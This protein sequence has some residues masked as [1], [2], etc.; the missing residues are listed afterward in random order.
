MS[1]WSSHR[2]YLPI[3]GRLLLLVLLGLLFSGSAVAGATPIGDIA[4]DGARVTVNVEFSADVD[5]TVL[6]ELHLRSR[7]GVSIDSATFLPPVGGGAATVN[8]DGDFLDLPRRGWQ[9]R[10]ELTQGR[11]TLDAMDVRFALECAA[12]RC[13]VVA[14]PDVLIEGAVAA[15]PDLSNLLAAGEAV[16]FAALLATEPGLAG[17]LYGASVDLAGLSNRLRCQCFFVA[18]AGVGGQLQTSLLSAWDPKEG[19]DGALVV[20]YGWNLLDATQDSVRAGHGSQ[21]EASMDFVCFQTTPGATMSVPTSA[22]A[23]EISPPVLAPC[24]QRCAPTVHW[25]AEP[26]WSVHLDSH[27]DA[28]TEASFHLAWG[29]DGV[30]QNQE[31]RYWFVPGGQIQPVSESSAVGGNQT[32]VAVTVLPSTLDFTGS[33]ETA[34]SVV[35]NDDRPKVEVAAGATIKATG[36]AACAARP[37]VLQTRT[38]AI[39]SAM[40]STTLAVVLGPEDPC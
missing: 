12:S 2:R 38:Q 4:A 24:H 13:Q 8:L 35:S 5:P 26:V 23:M 19:D 11:K 22:G 30:Q 20:H 25:S 1:I 17:D 34:L 37:A 18:D 31:S 3:K 29:V 9:H 6:V 28:T 16:D 27:I 39:D 32:A 10:V 21:R 14:R 33:A 36:H 40:R 7:A 15:G